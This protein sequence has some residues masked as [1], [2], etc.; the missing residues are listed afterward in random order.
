MPRRAQQ[1]NTQSY[2]VTA[3]IEGIIASGVYAGGAGG[4]GVAGALGTESAIWLY[5]MIPGEYGCRVRPGS[6]DDTINIPDSL[7]PN[8]QVRTAM[9]FNSIV[10]GGAQDK[11]FA[12]T[13]QGIYDISG[14]GAGP[15]VLGDRTADLTWPA[16][17]GD[18][19]W[20]SFL[21]YTNVGGDHFILA[22]DEVNGFWIFDGAIWAAGTFTGSP[23]PLASDLVQISEW[24]GRVWFVEKNT[25]RAWFLDPLALAGAIEP[26]DVGN[27]FKEGGHLV[28]CSTWT[29]D[30]GDGMDDKFVMISAAGDVL[31]W[32][33]LDPTTAADLTLQGRWTV[34]SV[35]EGRR[36]MSDWGGDVAILSTAGLITLSA[37]LDGTSALNSEKYI[38]RNV[39]QYMRR[40]M[41][42]TLDEYGWSMELVPRQ[43]I[44]IFTVPQPVNSTRAPIQF[45]LETATKSWAFFRGLPMLSTTKRGDEFIFST[46]DG[47]V[48]VMAGT[49]DNVDIGGESGIAIPFSLL[50]HYSGMDQPAIWKRAQFIRPYWIGG[51]QPSF[52]IQIRWDFDLTEL[53]TAPS[54]TSSELSLWDFAIWDDAKWEGSAQSFVETIGVGGMGRHAAIAIRGSATNALTYLGADVMFDQGGML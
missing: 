51:A 54:Y 15:W 30:A 7:G 14:G 17:G 25:A 39:N 44:A 47:R 8:G 38:S 46:Y 32:Q 29:I 6:R 50:T 9:F 1:Q 52:N 2:G 45:V 4:I 40:E 11:T 34:G 48:M 28:Q 10:A 16:Q 13:D 24:N 27:R 5:N 20:I 37:L 53:P 23:A 33:G 19:G 31:V 36:V 35:P 22:C 42:L 41:E 26:F 43:G 3:P 49:L 12:A 21:N 18:A